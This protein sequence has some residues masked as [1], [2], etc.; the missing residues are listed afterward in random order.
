VVQTL[1]RC[2]ECGLPGK[3][4][5]SLEWR[6]GGIISVRRAKS[7]RLV[8]IDERTLSDMVTDLT[9]TVGAEPLHFAETEATR[10]ATTGLMGGIKG[11]LSRYSGIKKRILEAIE[12]YSLLLGMGRIEL[13]KFSPGEGG[14]MLLR[15][16]F[17]L[18]ITVAGVSGALEEMD[19]C[20]YRSN[21]SVAGEKAYRLTLDVRKEEERGR[22]RRGPVATPAR[23]ITGRKNT[24]S[25]SQ[26]GLPLP[27]AGLCWDEMYG[28]IQAGTDGRRVAFLPAFMLEALEQI[29]GDQGGSAE[30]LEEAVFNSI[31][32]GL[33]EGKDDIYESTAI[34]LSGNKAEAVSRRINM[35]GWGAVTSGRLDGVSW[36][37]EVTNP[38]SNVLIAGW[39]RALYTVAM[40][41]E[42]LVKISGEAPLRVFELG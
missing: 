35:R 8:L 41:K 11:R 24:E 10:A 13:E 21:V 15:K 7:L 20:A 12:D 19:Q 18:G 27:V 17:E 28:V 26:C 9:A 5:E 40:R 6:S 31:R 42:P 36:H 32:N 16:P 29:S 4:A 30:A 37:V 38:I 3:L 25:C 39:L 23:A 34:L 2:R 22:S 33:E 1:A 14:S